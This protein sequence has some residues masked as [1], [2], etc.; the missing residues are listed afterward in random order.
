[1]NS[2]RR[3]SQVLCVFMALWNVA[4][5]MQLTEEKEP[6]IPER[7]KFAEGFVQEA[8]DYFLRDDVSVSQASY[9]FGFNEKKWYKKEF[10]PFILSDD[11]IAHIYG[12]DSSVIWNALGLVKVHGKPVIK[13]MLKKADGGWVSMPWYNMDKKNYVR[14]VFKNGQTYVIGTGFY[15]ESDRTAI[16]SLVQQGIDSI[17][18][19]GAKDTFSLINNPVEALVDGDL[20]LF[21]YDMDGTCVAHGDNIALVGQ[22]LMSWKDE[23]GRLRHKEMIEFAQKNGRGWFEYQDKGLKKIVY[24]ELATDLAT[25]RTYVMGGGYYPEIDD[26]QTIS[27][28]KKGVAFLKS[29][30]LDDTV[31]AIASR[32][33]LL[34]SLRSVLY[35]MEGKVLADS[36]VPKFVGQNLMNWKDQDGKTVVRSIIEQ[37][38]KFE[39]GWVSSM[40]KNA[41]KLIYY[42]RVKIPGGTYVLA[43]GYYPANKTHWTKAIVD[44][45][46]ETMKRKTLDEAL[47]LFTGHNKEFL[48]G[49]IY[50]Y[51]Y[52]AQGYCLAAGPEKQRIWTENLANRMDAK[53]NRLDQ[54]FLSVAT[55]G[56]GWVEYTHPQGLRRAYLQGV[57][58]ENPVTKKI[59]FYIVGAGYFL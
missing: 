40:D 43:A 19:K 50:V 12:W 20:Y 53:G 33:L 4:L 22:N 6:N 29:H 7:E 1:M 39:S 24:L 52:D 5:G 14:A 10:F 42:E 34:G 58:L 13:E 41:Y 9:E 16:E 48:R 37:A 17:I 18:E 49:D 25:K 47:R 27:F 54:L 3:R 8:V 38:K 15:P 57:E 11:G 21:V 46:V 23:N 28:V 44:K 36:D 35:D 59:D 2:T 32:E 55:R 30:G 56:G 31:D 51:V 26:S 45:A